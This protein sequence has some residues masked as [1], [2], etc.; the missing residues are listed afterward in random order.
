VSSGTD[1]RS[2]VESLPHSDVPPPLPAEDT[3]EEK[4]L[5][6]LLWK[7]CAALVPRCLDSGDLETAHIFCERMLE[8]KFGDRPL[9]G[10][11]A[12]AKALHVY[13]RLQVLC[14][15]GEVTVESIV[16]LR[17]NLYAQYE[18]GSRKLM[19]WGHL[20]LGRALSQLCGPLLE[21]SPF[22]LKQVISDLLFARNDFLRWTLRWDSPGLSQCC[23]AVLSEFAV[24]LRR[25]SRPE[26]ALEFAALGLQLLQVLD[27][28]QCPQEDVCG[29]LHLLPR[30]KEEENAWDA[31]GE[32][33]LRG[34]KPRKTSSETKESMLLVA[35]LHEE[36]GHIEEATHLLED[37]ERQA[38]EDDY[39]AGE[40]LFRV[41]FQLSRLYH[42]SG[43][44]KE[45]QLEKLAD[46]VEM[47]T[48]T[49]LRDLDHSHPFDMDTLVDALVR[50]I[51]LDRTNERTVSAT[52]KLAELFR[53]VEREAK[54]SV[55]ERGQMEGVRLLLA[56]AWHHAKG[57]ANTNFP[58]FGVDPAV[59][60]LSPKTLSLLRGEVDLLD[61]DITRRVRSIHS[62]YGEVM[63]R[64]ARCLLG[65]RTDGSG[66]EVSSYAA[67]CFSQLVVELRSLLDVLIPAR[68][69]AH[70]IRM[71]MFPILFVSDDFDEWTGKVRDELA[72]STKRVDDFL[73]HVKQH[74]PFVRME[75]TPIPALTHVRV[76]AGDEDIPAAAIPIPNPCSSMS[77]SFTSAKANGVSAGTSL[78]S[79][80]STAASVA[81]GASA[82]LSSGHQ[83]FCPLEVGN[84]L[85][86]EFKHHRFRRVD[87][88]GDV[89]K[90]RGGLVV[91]RTTLELVYSVTFIHKWTLAS[92]LER[93]TRCLGNEHN[94]LGRRTPTQ[95]L[96]LSAALHELFVEAG[97]LI[98]DDKKSLHR[99]NL[100]SLWVSLF[101]DL[102]RA[103]AGFDVRERLTSEPNDALWR[104]LCD[105]DDDQQ[106]WGWLAEGGE[107]PS[108][109]DLVRCAEQVRAQFDSH[110]GEIV[111]KAN[112]ILLPSECARNSGLF[113][114]SVVHRFRLPELIALE[115]CVVDVFELVHG[116]M[117]EVA[118][119][120]DVLSPLVEES[121]PASLHSPM[122]L[123]LPTS[124]SVS[125]CI[126]SLLYP[127]REL[128]HT[129]L[130]RG[131]SDG[132][133]SCKRGW[134]EQ[135]LSRRLVGALIARRE[136]EEPLA[137]ACLR[138]ANSL[139]ALGLI[140]LALDQLEEDLQW[141]VGERHVLRLQAKKAELAESRVSVPMCP[142]LLEVEPLLFARLEQI[143]EQFY[144]TVLPEMAKLRNPALSVGVS[145]CC[146]LSL[147]LMFFFLHALASAWLRL[148]SFP[149]LTTDG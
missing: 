12:S 37:V 141:V 140:P 60:Y 85:N 80:S 142:T 116:M 124:P 148:T 62:I 54:Q 1:L 33:K 70:P 106:N 29:I 76:P 79:A 137:D 126:R 149:L 40:Q 59:E 45:E 130:Y 3:D 49:F 135:C 95:L 25:A 4:D 32:H 27:V 11:M 43:R 20:Q 52:E 9:S 100:D 57:G 41:R 28:A 14:L 93:E 63:C 53:F 108:K 101:V 83:A 109:E 139:V 102:S 115:S 44:T 84:I 146:V 120:V 132:R 26:R 118:E 36:L 133:F 127:F 74:Q 86:N 96:N 117:E 35:S 71:R 19:A 72:K 92:C 97:V 10:A 7:R 56:D 15:K 90:R 145:F 144:C 22:L 61:S 128:S 17:K 8:E 78:S 134:L 39:R 104:S 125:Y 21:Q 30:P 113:L 48:M 110:V 23:A 123:D 65:E 75:R 129:S 119:L 121:K 5:V 89:A 46:L 77:S 58:D 13:F 68:L 99:V 18:G 143:G 111:K 16:D 105:D 122:P 87:L 103:Y 50:M 88:V 31:Q 64:I 51:R 147:F 114:S 67:G 42:T 2:I 112:L 91:R 138:N 69:G 81:D 24:L 47:A 94:E 66:G 82:T 34:G 131:L 107:K 38:L 98:L 136:F 55:A 6:D 73:K